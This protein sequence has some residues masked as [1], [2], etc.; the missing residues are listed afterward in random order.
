LFVRIYSIL[1]HATVAQLDASAFFTRG[2]EMAAPPPQGQMDIPVIVKRFKSYVLSEC[3]D[4][5]MV[6]MAH[7]DET[8]HFGVYVR[9]AFSHG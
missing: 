9:F 1:R 3:R 4:Q 2:F 5:L 6:I 8:K 7:S